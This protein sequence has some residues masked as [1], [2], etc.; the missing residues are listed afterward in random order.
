MRSNYHNLVCISSRESTPKYF[1]TVKQTFKNV[2]FSDLAESD[3]QK[4]SITLAF[5][6]RDDLLY[7]QVRNLSSS[8]LRNLLG[9]ESYGALKKSAENARRSLNSH[10]LY[11]IKRRLANTPSGAAAARQ[12]QPSPV[13]IREARL[14]ATFRGG[15]KE[16]LHG[17]YPYLEGYS[18]QFVEDI[19]KE[20]MP[21]ARRI[22]DPFAGVGTTPL[23]A[24]KLGREAFYCEL[25]PLLQTL[26]EAKSTALALEA[27]ARSQIALGIEEIARD[28]EAK[29]L[30]CDPSAQLERAY[31]RTFGG[32]QFFE[33]DAFREVLRMRTFV[34]AL[35]AA[36]AR[37]ARFVELAALS[38]LI[39][40][41]R[42]IRRGDL[43][44]K[45]G[46]ELVKPTPRFVTAAR[47][48]LKRFA[49]DLRRTE[50]IPREP[51]LVCEDARR[52]AGL[53][54]LAIEG[55]IS[56]PPYLNGTNYFRNTKVELWFLRALHDESDL[57]A[58]R[59]KAVTAGINDVT[60]AKLE[61]GQVPE[62]VDLIRRLESRAYDRRIPQMVAAYFSDMAEVLS[63]ITFHL[64]EH[65]RVAL[66]IGDSC[67]GGVHVP[68]HR[69]VAQLAGGV[70]LALEREIVLRRRTSR[71][72]TPLSQ[73]LL[74]FG[75]GGRRIRS[76]RDEGVKETTPEWT[77]TW[78]RFKEEL[79]H[80]R[81][82]FAKRNWGHGLH[83]LCSYQGKMKPAL[84]HFLVKTFVPE[85]GVMLDPFAGVGTIPFEAA[86][87]GRRSFAFDISP[88]A[89]QIT[90]A[91]LQRPEGRLCER[92]L[93]ALEDHIADGA[94]DARDRESVSRINFNGNLASYFSQE[95]LK[96]VLLARRF[97]QV[98]PP[99]TPE[100]CLVFTSL[101]H[102]LHGNRPYALSRRS[103]PITPFAP[104]GG[105]EY[106]ALMPR[107]REKVSRSL[108]LDYPPEYL[109]GE[110]FDQDVTGW[111]PHRVDELDAIITS[112]PFFDSTRFYLANWMRLWFCGWD[113]EE[114]RCRP[115]AFVDE[116]QKKSFA[117]YEP[118][119]RQARERLKPGGVLVL[120]LGK[121][122]KC[123]MGSVL[124]LMARRWFRVADAFDES[125]EH[126]ES[127]GIRDKGTVTSHQ[128]LVLD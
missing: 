71:D 93:K 113:E 14:Q 36:A 32:S 74:V 6:Q 52:L 55:L 19:L 120:H 94:V 58:F 99:E 72:G 110:V 116:R 101:L 107:L 123:D 128:F 68:T 61:A 37:E 125:V 77:R 54:H 106:R 25:N 56:S 97:F 16:P 78:R 4:S 59:A 48:Y 21:D 104:T 89:I 47:D 23:T 112:P 126:C 27:S 119:F 41:S 35:Y 95:T 85:G 91:K 12:Q 22:L 63:A 80:Q 90:R 114:F 67:Y 24:T 7:T 15:M 34:D 39:P 118:F 33:E 108:E 86:L 70:G 65:A 66:D 76:F 105:F 30:R 1:Q 38:G 40:A 69:I 20:F 3:S 121:S 46:K 43:R 17:W 122:R 98:H 92:W 26:T 50:R 103:H 44:F 84:A 81:G 109:A 75:R 73:V 45:T 10:C 9:F 87:S 124:G 57:S 88:A 117:V 111:W 100:A 96:E 8:E 5:S 115:L 60:V 51:T 28:I 62:A 83:S 79:P 31:A 42:L 127:H 53:P 29:V 82:F 49:H 11:R 64:T 13:V 18:P 102:I 2:Y